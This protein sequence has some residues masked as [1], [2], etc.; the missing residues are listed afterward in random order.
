MVCKHMWKYTRY[1]CANS[2]SSK[3]L[4]QK[5]KEK[6]YIQNM[7]RFIIYPIIILDTFKACIYFTCTLSISPDQV[8]PYRFGCGGG[9][10]PDGGGFTHDSRRLLKD[11]NS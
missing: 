10:R 6:T 7:Y 8:Y 4:D 1:K 9:H 5:L 2:L 11:L 3:H